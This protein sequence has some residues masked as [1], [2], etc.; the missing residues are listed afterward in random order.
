MT[1]T[2]LSANRWQRF[3]FYSQVVLKITSSK[4]PFLLIPPLEKKNAERIV[5]S[6]VS[7]SCGGRG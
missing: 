4:D 7:L 5:V 1:F 6:D 3:Q 2:L